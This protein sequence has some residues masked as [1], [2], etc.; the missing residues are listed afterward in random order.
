LHPLLVN[1]EHATCATL[2]SWG[3]SFY[4]NFTDGTAL[5]SKYTPFN[6]VDEETKFYRYNCEEDVESAW[7]FHQA[8]RDYFRSMGSQVRHYLCFEDYVEISSRDDLHDL[9]FDKQADPPAVLAPKRKD[10]STKCPSCGAP[11]PL[12]Y[13]GMTYV[14]CDYCGL[15]AP[16]DLS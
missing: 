11:L 13:S 3:V 7:A 1:K 15:V 2:D 14:T 8:Q 12:I 5:V 9:T 4:T 6:V 16:V 10:V